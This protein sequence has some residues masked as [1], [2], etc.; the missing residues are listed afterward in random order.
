MK[1]TNP[2]K[3]AAGPKG[4]YHALRMAWKTL[5]PGKTFRI[6]KS[7]NQKEGIDCPGCAWPD[8]VHRSN[9]GEFCENGVKA[10]A[11]EAMDAN[12]DA[13]FFAKYDVEGMRAQSDYWLGQQGRLTQP[14]YIQR[15]ETHYTP[16]AWEQ[17]FELVA[18]KLNALKQPD[19]AIFYT[20]GRTSNEAAFLY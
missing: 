7:L 16:I 1:F 5:S 20:S 8:P 12:A 17:A 11:E 4:V 15:G 6:L 9:L 10:I 14:M 2:P 3:S 18:K 13:A 19:D